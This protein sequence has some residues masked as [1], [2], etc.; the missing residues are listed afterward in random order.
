VWGIDSGFVRQRSSFIV[1]RVAQCLRAKKSELGRRRSAGAWVTSKT[2]QVKSVNNRHRLVAGS[3]TPAPQSERT[4]DAAR[5]TT[6]Q[7]RLTGGDGEQE[8]IQCV[9]GA[10]SLDSKRVEGVGAAE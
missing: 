4:H 2:V 9:D 1:E 5:V 6:S 3:R 8:Q 10:F 7:I